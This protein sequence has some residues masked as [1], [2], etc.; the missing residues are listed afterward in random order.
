MVSTG[1]TSAPPAQDCS[2]ALVEPVDIHPS[3]VS[4][5]FPVRSCRDHTRATLFIVAS[6][7]STSAPPD[8]ETQ[9]RALIDS[10]EITRFHR[11]PHHH[12]RRARVPRP[13]AASRCGS[14]WTGPACAH[15]SALGVFVSPPL[16][17]LVSPER[18]R[19]P[20]VLC[21]IFAAHREPTLG[22]PRALTLAML[23]KPQLQVPRTTHI[24]RPVGA[25]RD[26]RERHT[27]QD[28]PRPT[29]NRVIH[30]RM[31]RRAP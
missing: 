5:R 27:T 31:S 28:A 30:R 9:P 10:A 17:L 19:H 25:P 7:Y 26:T 22:V 11:P 12:D 23:P 16:I 8:P 14:V 1:S 2:A 6:K 21:E 13:G 4:R 29:F 18:L 24:E 15:L 3:P 20:L